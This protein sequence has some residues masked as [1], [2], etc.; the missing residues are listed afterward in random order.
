M[1]MANACDLCDG[2]GGELLFNNGSLR[3]VLVDEPAY[4]G[5]CRVIWNGHVKE[6]T[7][8]APADRSAVMS[9]VW[10]VETAVREVMQPEKMNVA[11]LGNMTP[12]VHWHVIP[13]FTD[14]RHFPSPVWAE[15]RRPADAA[16]IAARRARLPQ[17]REAVR[18]QLDAAG[19][20]A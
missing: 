11:S 7:D 20:T 18:R 10:A 9:A 17:L 1:S 14:D 5:F 15:P 13:R 8:L 2:D 4:P 12:H 6:M 19:L 3:V 16:S